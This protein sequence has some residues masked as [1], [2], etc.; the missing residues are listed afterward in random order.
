MP[1]R[2]SDEHG[3]TRVFAHWRALP[4]IASVSPVGLAD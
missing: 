1:N 3:R 4:R 2:M